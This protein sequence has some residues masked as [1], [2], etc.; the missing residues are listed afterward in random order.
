MSLTLLSIF[1]SYTQGSS[2]VVNEVDTTLERSFLMPA[3]TKE[4][5]N[6]YPS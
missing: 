1:S 3:K 4:L 6:L 5:D 2:L